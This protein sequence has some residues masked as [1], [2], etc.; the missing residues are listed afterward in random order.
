MLEKGHPI[1]F[2]RL[3][4]F[5]ALPAISSVASHFQRCQQ[6]PA[7]PAFSSVASARRIDKGCHTL[8]FGA[9]PCHALAADTNMARYAEITSSQPGWRFDF[10][11]LE[12][13]DPG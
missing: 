5:P 9:V 4:Q 2:Q 7:L 11:I 12:A 3:Q 8:P 13:E 1:F 10:A 6:F